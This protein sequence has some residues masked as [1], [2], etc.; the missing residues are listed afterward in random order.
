MS[1]IGKQSIE[2][3][4]KVKVKLEKQKIFVEGPKGSLSRILPSVI[5][6]TLDT[7]KNQLFLEKAE[8]TRLAQALY[9]LSR[10][11]VANMVTGV[12]D[13]FS[14]KLQ[15]SGVGYRAQL[16]GKDLILN[17]GYSHP[18]KMVPPPGISVTLEGQTT[19]IVSGIA[20]DTVG[21]FAAKIR[22]VRPP[23]PY[24]GK[25]IAYDGEFIR[26]KAGKTGK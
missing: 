11:L 6:C 14:K 16:E 3:P 20:L 12:S 17:M 19:I 18:V 4:Q 5:C 1:R 26:R 24:K 13:G 15:I 21:E 10:T 7:E 8:E 25:G 22:S 2:V 9:G 23:E